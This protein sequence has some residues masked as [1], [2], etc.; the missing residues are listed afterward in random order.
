MSEEGKKLKRK[1]D[2]PLSYL[3]ED[4]SK[5]ARID[6]RQVDIEEMIG[7]GSGIG[8]LRKRLD[9]IIRILDSGEESESSERE[10]YREGMGIKYAIHVMT[11]KDKSGSQ[12]TADT[13][14]WLDYGKKIR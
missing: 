3:G 1:L 4:R 14:R 12:R 6:G 11:R 9:E 5:Y 2:E 13:R 7:S 8:S 10:L